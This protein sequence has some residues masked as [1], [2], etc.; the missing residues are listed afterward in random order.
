MFYESLRANSDNRSAYTSD[1]II[2]VKDVCKQHTMWSK[3][4]CSFICPGY[5]TPVDQFLPLFDADGRFMQDMGVFNIGSID[6]DY[7]AAYDLC[8]KWI[9]ILP[10][11]LIG[12]F[13]LLQ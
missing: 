1:L 11:L 8:T 4:G 7:E 13:F 2:A 5:S 6:E 12:V 10:P 3:V 9:L